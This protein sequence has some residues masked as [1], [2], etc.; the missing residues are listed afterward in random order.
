MFQLVQDLIPF[1]PFASVNG[2]NNDNL[3]KTSLNSCNVMKNLWKFINWTEKHKMIQIL[4]EAY[5]RYKKQIISLWF[6]FF[7]GENPL[8]TT[9]NN[10]SVMKLVRNFKN[11]FKLPKCCQIFVK[12][13]KLDKEAW[14]LFDILQKSPKRCL[15]FGKLF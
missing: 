11:W 12:F 9:V 13:R 5:K 14:I 8:K 3:L 2:V 6:F 4:Q 1:L 7:Y 10:W 15:K